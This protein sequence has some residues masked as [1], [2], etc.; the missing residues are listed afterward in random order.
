MGS[1]AAY[2]AAGVKGRGL[3]LHRLSF[4]SSDTLAPP[5]V[6]REILGKDRHA[7][8]SKQSTFALTIDSR[9]HLASLVHSQN[10]VTERFV[11]YAA[12]LQSF[13]TVIKS[14]RKKV[15]WTHPR[16]TPAEV[17]EYHFIIAEPS[18]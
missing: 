6:L 12:R 1:F 3:V 11:T 7:K 13:E 18:C 16:P 5:K 14:G 9:R 4:S 8:E 10:M 17:H 2:T 15:T